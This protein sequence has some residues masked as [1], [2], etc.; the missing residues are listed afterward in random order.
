M[1]MQARA[2]I[3]TGLLAAALNRRDALHPWANEVFGRIAGP[4]LTSEANFTEACHLLDRETLKGSLRLYEFAETGLLHIVSLQDSLPEVQAH[5]AR[6]RDR[7]VDFADACLL[8]LA[9][10]F[11]R[12]PIITTDRADFTVYLR[13]QKQRLVL[14]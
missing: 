10:R 11:P 9:G 8:V 3:D 12:L 7:R 2:L 14:P 1:A 4:Y 6:Y 5:V 13:E